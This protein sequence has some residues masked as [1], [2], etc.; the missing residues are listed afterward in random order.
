MK[1]KKSLGQNFLTSE[2]AIFKITHA[3]HITPGEKVL[4]VGPGRGVLTKS[5]LAAGAH[6]IA[7][8]KDNRLISELGEKFSVEVSDKKLTVIEKDILETTPQELGLETG[9]YKIVANLPYYITGQFLRNFLSTNNHPNTMVLL[10]Q[11]EVVERIIARD[12]KESLLSLSIKAY[13]APKKITVVDRG[14]FQPAPNVD[15]AVIAI[16]NISKGFFDTLTEEKFF[17]VIKAAFAHKR[18]ILVSNLSEIL[19]KEKVI[20][21]L[22]ELNLS[23]K[24][25]AEDLTLETWK[26]IIEK[27]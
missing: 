2:A 22:K 16:E 8:E 27:L 5:L 19:D 10:L 3:A 6:V 13:G 23:E 12:G 15:S 7:V 17:Q 26:K 11:K 1:A 24:S 21:V 18:K 14:S 9:K 4:E 20:A 25:R